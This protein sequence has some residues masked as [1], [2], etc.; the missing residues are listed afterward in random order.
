MTYYLTPFNRMANLKRAM[1]HIH[2][3]GFREIPRNMQSS[4]YIPLNVEVNDE[5]YVI[6]ALLPGLK[7][8]DVH[9]QVLNNTITIQGELPMLVLEESDLVRREIPSGDFRRAIKLP[10]ALDPEKAE[11]TIEDGVL[12]LRVLMAET[13]RPKTIEVKVK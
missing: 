7:S 5:A 2:P 9:I 6:T 8:E 3:E 1:E 12:H 10:M 11:A 13:E 4:V